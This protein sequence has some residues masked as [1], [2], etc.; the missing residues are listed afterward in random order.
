MLFSEVSVEFFRSA[1]QFVRQQHPKKLGSFLYDAFEGALG[2]TN[3]L[4]HRQMQ[5]LGR[6][7]LQEFSPQLV[8]NDPGVLTPLAKLLQ[9][10]KSSSP[11]S[12]KKKLCCNSMVVKNRL[13]PSF[14]RAFRKQW[15]EE[16][17]G[18][19]GHIYAHVEAHNDFRLF[20]PLGRSLVDQLDV[21]SVRDVDQ[22]QKAWLRVKSRTQGS[23]D[24]PLPPSEDT[25]T[26]SEAP[27][28]TSSETEAF[29]DINKIYRFLEETEGEQ[30]ASVPKTGGR[31]VNIIPEKVESYRGI[32][33]DENEPAFVAGVEHATHGKIFVMVALSGYNPENQM[34]YR[35]GLVFV[36]GKGEVTHRH[37]N[38]VFDP[39][40]WDEDATRLL[41]KA[42]H[43]QSG[44]Y[45]K[46]WTNVR[47][48]G[49]THWGDIESMKRYF[50]LGE[51]PEV[52]FV[53]Q[54]VYDRH[55]R[56]FL[57]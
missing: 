19:L 33:C 27:A 8:L 51:F 50:I 40:A 45:G 42:I 32:V 41:A 6:D 18:F 36:P 16:V 26:P 30:L 37:L 12:R 20:R 15:P 7:L 2:K 39:V 56:R 9:D 46:Y 54:D 48:E 44:I 55:R 52:R 38:S 34:V 28:A 10:Q 23:L 24:T 21:R 29:E 4:D 13:A 14:L 43:W 1:I 31:R 57:R 47:R 53:S 49:E 25:S 35:G 17:G 22:L 3:G 11:D 5:S